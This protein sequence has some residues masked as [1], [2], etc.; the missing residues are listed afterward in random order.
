M[1]TL[2]ARIKLLS[3]SG[4]FHIVGSNAINKMVTFISSII[5]VRILTKGEY[6]LFTYA[7]NIYSIILLFNGM[8][9]D[10][11]VLQLGSE[12]S[13]DSTYAEKLSNYAVRFGLRFN[14]L[15]TVAILAVG[16]FF[17]MEIEGAGVLLCML[18]LLPMPKLIS[19]INGVYLRTQKRNKEMS[20]VSVLTTIVVL[21]VTNSCAWLF[22]EKGLIL[23]YYIAYTFSIIITTWH[24]KLTYLKGR[25]TLE[26]DERK[27]LFTI[28]FVSMCNNGLSQLLYL[29]DVFVLGIVVPD[30]SVLASYKVATTI[31]SALTFIPIAVMV[32]LYPY[33]A[34]NRTDGK[35]CMRKYG[36]VLG[37]MGAFNAVVSATL[38]LFAPFVV[39]T[40]FGANYMDAVPIFRLLAIN[41]FFSGTFR[42]LSGNLLVT[43]RKLKFN[44][45]IAVFSGIGNAVANFFFIQWWGSMGAAIATVCVVILTS[46]LNTVYL[47]HT[48]KKAS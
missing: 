6:G 40:F 17:P 45:Y 10:S 18:C 25:T 14:I 31:P 23:G 22:R 5:V 13:G 35:W 21:V 41:Y 30:E 3:Q 34:Q 43:Q 4:A 29:L 8:G 44:L 7:W 38:F 12:K 47:L 28:S 48:F 24:C 39:R 32:Y 19:A 15:L 33:F 36:Q 42:I 27:T 37:V 20:G 9:I 1:K 46:I 11:G 2:L 16:L 26:R